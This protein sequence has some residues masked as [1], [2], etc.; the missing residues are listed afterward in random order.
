MT[1]NRLLADV[2]HV[3]S[4]TGIRWCLL[5]GLDQLEQPAGD[6]DLLI[7]KADLARARPLLLERGFIRL[8]SA[9]RASHSFYLAYDNSCSQWVELDLVTELA[10]GPAFAYQTFAEAACLERRVRDGDLYLPQPED[11]FWLLW[12]HC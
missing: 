12:L 9:G 1:L 2:F 6:V 10:F 8:S 7:A 11:Q 5:R 3:F 4:A